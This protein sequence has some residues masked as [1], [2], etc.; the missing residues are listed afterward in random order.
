[1]ARG[2]VI[3]RSAPHFTIPKP[4]ISGDVTPQKM[5][6]AGR[7]YRELA[8]RATAYASRVPGENTLKIIAAGE[9]MD[10][11]VHLKSAA[12]GLFDAKSKLIAQSSADAREL[13]AMPYVAA[14]PAAS[15][16]YRLRFAA[17]DNEGHSG[18]VDY[19]F[20]AELTTSG[21][22]KLSDIALGVAKNGAFAPRLLFGNEQAV[23]GV[24]EIYGTPRSS[25]EVTVRLELAASEEGPPLVGVPA[26]IRPTTETDKRS[27]VAALPLESVPPGDYVVRAVVN[28]DGRPVAHVYRTLRKAHAK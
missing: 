17:L 20:R 4:E 15:G 14:I 9:P 27:V 16:P 21:T 12:V 24:L 2:N 22:L 23:L 19:W 18:T 10:S 28:V 26:S 5:L 1:V 8:L 6:R 11:S 13:T 3:V 25:S 7:A